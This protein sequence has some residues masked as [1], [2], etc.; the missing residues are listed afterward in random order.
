[1]VCRRSPFFLSHWTAASLPRQYPATGLVLRQ[2]F[3]TF[4]EGEEDGERV[5]VPEDPLIRGLTNFGVTEGDGG[6]K[7]FHETL[8]MRVTVPPHSQS[9]GVNICPKEHS[10]FAEVLFHFNP[11]R[12]FVAMNNR[13]DNVWGQQVNPCVPGV[14]ATTTTSLYSP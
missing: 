2:E 13:E 14:P 10:D 11:R 8:V 1:M 12:R 4:V 5:Y 3:R 7:P 9:W 6:K